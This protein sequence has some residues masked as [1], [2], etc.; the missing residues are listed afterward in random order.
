MGGCSG[1]AVPEEVL[2]EVR[3]RAKRARYAA[4]LVAPLTRRSSSGFAKEMRRYQDTLGELQDCVTAQHWMEAIAADPSDADV[5]FLAGK[6]WGRFE[7]REEQA[8][9][10]FLDR[11]NPDRAA[12]KGSWFR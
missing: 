2:H 11:W 12:R 7:A 4:E 5:V 10:R 9:D 3:K 8:A 6:L 1:R